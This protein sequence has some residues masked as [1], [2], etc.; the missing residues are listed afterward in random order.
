M[1]WYKGFKGIKR[2]KKI[3]WCWLI[4]AEWR[5]YASGNYVII[6]SDNGL[7]SVRR[8]AITWTKAEEL[9][10]ASQGTKFSEI[11]SAIQTVSF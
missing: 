7:S 6:G 10:I 5:I 3:K 11:L 8:Q 2:I 1:K 9:W 4:E